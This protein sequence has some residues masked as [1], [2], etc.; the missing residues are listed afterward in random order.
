MIVLA[1]ATPLLGFGLLLL[2]Q[3]LEERMM[4]APAQVVPAPPE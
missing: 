4:A 2:M 3:R 1:L